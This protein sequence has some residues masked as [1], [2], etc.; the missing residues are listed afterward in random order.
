MSEQ[1]TPLHWLRQ[2]ANDAAGERAVDCLDHKLDFEALEGLADGTAGQLFKAGLRSGQLLGLITHDPWKILEILYGVISLGAVLLPLDPRMSLPRRKR[3]LCSCGTDW[4]ISDNDQSP[5]VADIARMSGRGVSSGPG[6]EAMA[7]SGPD[8]SGL[9]LIIATSGTQGDPK[10]VMLTAGNL[11]TSAESSRRRLDLKPGDRWLNC[12]PL[13]HIGGLSIIYRCLGARATLN[14]HRGFDAREVWQEI[15]QHR[16]T[17]LSL[18]PAMLSLLLAESKGGAPPDTLRVVLV[19]GGPLSGEL[20][21]RAHEARWPLCI[22]YGLSE[23]ASQVATDCGER[24]GLSAGLVGRPME[25]IE[26]GMTQGEEGLIRI[27][28][29]AVMAG[30]AN[31]ERLPGDGLTAGWFKTGDL[32][33][34]TEEGCLRVLGRR[35]DLLVSAGKNIHPLE[36]EERLLG[37]PGIEDAGVSACP[38][39]VWGERLVALVA[40]TVASSELDRWVNE[41][42]P[43]YLRPRR[44]IRVESL[45]RNTMGKL[46]RGALRKLAGTSME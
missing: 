19:G 41:N 45:P 26:L 29:K 39:P 8:G 4:L 30:Y 46:D 24:A 21:A 2:R 6:R 43:G 35:D 38:D 18:V 34:I 37:C 13:H 23:A 14:L 36:V 3:L 10:G 42:M 28:G 11:V 27:R 7:S 9:Q 16:A 20:A 12:L 22:T 25:G 40:G 33:Q 17:H 15:K 32:G 5:L 44:F 31:P 1:T